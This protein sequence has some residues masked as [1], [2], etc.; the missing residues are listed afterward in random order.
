MLIDNGNGTHT[1]GSADVLCILK[2]VTTE[3]FHAAFFEESPMP[4][5]VKPIMELDFIRLKSK[6]H[7]TGG[8][9]TL[10][11]ALEHLKELSEKVKVPDTNVWKEPIDWDGVPGIVWMLPNWLK[12]A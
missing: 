5:P 10:D 9:D 11:G 8:A 2:D 4:G 12:K 3:R 6:M 7:H 1:A